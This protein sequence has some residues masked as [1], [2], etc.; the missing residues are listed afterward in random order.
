[1]NRPRRLILAA[2]DPAT[3]RLRIATWNCFGAPTSADE[4]MAGRPF[5]PERLE[6]PEVFAALAEHD[7]VCVQENL[8]PRVRESLDRLQRAGGFAELWFD[9][10]GPDMD[11]GTFVGGGLAILS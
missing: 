3:D 10:M 4:F 7:V 5:W 11:D 1:M 9:P 6:A 8:M 2:M